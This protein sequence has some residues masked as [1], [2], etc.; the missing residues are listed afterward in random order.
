[1]APQSQPSYRIWVRFPA[2]TG[3]GSHRSPVAQASGFLRHPH[4]CGAHADRK[5]RTG[6]GPDRR[7]GLVACGTHCQIRKRQCAFPIKITKHVRSGKGDRAS[8]TSFD[9]IN[10]ILL[11]FELYELRR[12]YCGKMQ[13]HINAKVE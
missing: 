13:A 9:G 4:S 11:Y 2:P 5:A 1:M 7:S 3:S 12:A 8:L 6:A 10:F